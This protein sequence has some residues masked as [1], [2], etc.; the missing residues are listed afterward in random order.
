MI[1]L[2]PLA[3]GTTFAGEYR[4]LELLSHTNHLALYGATHVTTGEIRVLELLFSPV[5]PGQAFRDRFVR[6]ALDTAR[7]ASPIVPRVI[8]AGIDG[9]SQV[10]FIAMEAFRGEVLSSAAMRSGGL[11]VAD[12]MVVLGQVT[13]ALSHLHANGIVHG[14]L[15][16]ESIVL[17]ADPT[18]R[19]AAKVLNAAVSKVLGDARVA[20]APSASPCDPS[21]SAPEQIEGEEANPAS[22]IY[23]FALLA[24]NVL[25]GQR[26]WRNAAEAQV[27]REATKDALPIPTMRAY[28]L[29]RGGTLPTTFDGWFARCAARNR[30]ERF[31]SID[32]AFAELQATFQRAASQFTG[33][34]S[35]M[36][37]A[38]HVMVPPQ[39]RSG[40]GAIAAIGV[41]GGLV[42]L[43]LLGFVGYRG[44]TRYQERALEAKHQLEAQAA[45]AETKTS[46]ADVSATDSQAQAPS[47]DPNVPSVDISSLPSA[48][49]SRHDRD[50][51]A[52]E[53]APEK[54]SEP[55]PSANANANANAN[56][57]TSDT[58]VPSSP[59]ALAE[60]PAAS[61]APA[62]LKV[63]DLSPG[64]GK[65]AK[66]G[67]NITVRYVAK[68]QADGVAYD[69][70]HSGSP[71]SFQL[72]TGKVTKG[73][74][75]GIP[76]MKV[77]GKRRLT[78]PPQLAYGEKGLGSNVPPNA[79]L[80]FDIELVSVD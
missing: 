54:R 26:I 49:R 37:S 51:R 24:F 13:A 21:W 72:G 79:T 75:Q 35:P 65:A 43:G 69:T 56:N 9:A 14:G 63:V 44:F 73:W 38:A 48:G 46:A 22:D 45:A 76:G 60:S 23:S 20:A 30:Q 58:S 34:I 6:A 16:P 32:I 64:K 40:S 68:R 29:G 66:S 39:K 10:P 47:G 8:A 25:T 50:R 61:A 78:V 17:T 62:K 18:H 2:P 31:P 67:D 77:G 3:Q 71:F 57:G 36:T 5:V 28:E 1:A 33:S 41:V 19:V 52:P 42:V 4:I 15:R 59:A 12:A 74:E 70:S 55:T 53:P 27:A 80:I 7:A 11:P